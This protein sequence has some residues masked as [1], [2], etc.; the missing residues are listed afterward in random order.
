MKWLLLVV[1][2]AVTYYTITYGQWALKKGFRRGAI[3]VFMLA[4]FTMAMA[5]YA[6]YFRE[7]F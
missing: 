7:S 6:L 4:A 1:P 5:V 3:G 2:L